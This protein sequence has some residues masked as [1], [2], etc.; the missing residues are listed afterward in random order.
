MN[1]D[2]SD[3]CYKRNSLKRV[4]VRVDLVSPINALTSALPRK[5]SKA[6]L[7]HFPIDEP[8]TGFTQEVRFSQKELLTRKED[9]TEWNFHGRNREKL[10]RITPD[11]IFIAYDV[12]E[13]FENLRSDFLA[14]TDSFFKAFE[15]AQPSRLGLR[16][17]N[18]IPKS[19]KD[20]L[21][22]TGII[23]DE[24]LSLFSYKVDGAKPSRIWHNIEFVDDGF[25]LRF[26][27]G[28]HNPDYPAPI[29]Q[30]LFVL[31]YDAYFQGL[32]DQGEIA[33]YL[34][35]YHLSIQQMYE[36]SITDNLRREMNEGSTTSA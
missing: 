8:K 26:Q 27:F 10:L 21:N 12:Y 7:K 35:K 32:I 9:Y 29:R 19:T 13:S 11:A 36:R 14:V 25:N 31:D 16:Y 18:E 2:L 5:V 6:A 4:I 22:W 20:P 34:D 1:E 17:V 24:L 30:K 28:V 33:G 23:A 15:E 3:I